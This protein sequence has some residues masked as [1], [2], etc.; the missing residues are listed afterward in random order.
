MPH[1][2]L[3]SDPRIDALR[4]W[5]H[6]FSSLGLDTGSAPAG[7][8]RRAAARFVQLCS[9][10][11]PGGLGRSLNRRASALR[12]SAHRINQ[13]HKES[14]L[15]PFLE[16]ALR[17]LHKEPSCVD[18]FCSDG[19]YCCVI[20]RISPAADVLGV[21]LGE[22]D[23]ERARLASRLLEMERIRFARED[24]PSFVSQVAGRFDLVF[25]AGGL[26]HLDEPRALLADLRRVCSGF[27]VLQTV[28]SLEN[29][30]S[31]Y[32][33]S[34]APGWSH[35]C[36]FS[37]ARLAGWLEELGWRVKETERN[38]LTGN[39]RPRDRGSSYFLCEAPPG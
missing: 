30:A 1:P 2:E 5:Y 36:R 21:D 20:A 35:G 24:V 34:P 32:F 27:L 22:S 39:N 10:T 7:K 23:L 4:P 18:L 9:R 33:E 17:R 11:L 29:E 19:Y 31:D 28:V 13:G 12:S 25:C 15:V 3:R 14:V 26:Y 37:H 16:E 8:L 6:D 38:E